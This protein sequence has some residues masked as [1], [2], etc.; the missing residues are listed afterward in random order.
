MKLSVFVEHIIRKN[1]FGSAWA[2]GWCW[3]VVSV[4]KPHFFVTA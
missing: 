3:Q 2:S 4:L 1:I